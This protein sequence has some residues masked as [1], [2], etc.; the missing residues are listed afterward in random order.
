M[1][2]REEAEF[3]RFVERHSRFVFRVAYAVLRNAHDAE[4][5][6]QETFLK[7][8]RN[9]AWRDVSDPHAFLAR[10]AWRVAVDRLPKRDDRESVALDLLDT[11]ASDLDP[12]Q[13]VIDA[14]AQHLIHQ[15]IDSLPEELRRPLAL[16]TIEELN[17]R[18]IASVMQLPEGTVRTRLMRARQMLREKL[19]AAERRTHATG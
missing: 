5:A 13:T 12:E 19:V 7:L 16:S 3:T 10:A 6:L 11:P 8:Y 18:E 17:S 15:M 1:H 14:T 4:D 9:G 2:E